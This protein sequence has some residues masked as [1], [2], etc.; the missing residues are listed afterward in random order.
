MFM[1][2]DDKTCNRTYGMITRSMVE[3]SK[4]TAI[5]V[6]NLGPELNFVA[7]STYSTI[8]PYLSEKSKE[9]PQ[10]DL[11]GAVWNYLDSFYSVL[12]GFS[13]LADSDNHRQIATKVKGLTNIANGIQLTTLTLLNYTS[14]AGF[15]FAAGAGLSFLHSLDDTIRCARRLLDYEYW[16]KDSEAEYQNL[17][18]QQTILKGEIAALEAREGIEDNPLSWLE[19]KTLGLKRERLGELAVNIEKL[20]ADIDAVKEVKRLT[21]E[22][23]RKARKQ[24]LDASLNSFAQG[25]SFIGMLIFCFPDVDVSAATFV[26]VAAGLYLFKHMGSQRFFGLI[27]DNKLPESEHEKDTDNLILESGDCPSTGIETGSDIEN[28]GVNVSHCEPDNED[29]DSDA[30]LSTEPLR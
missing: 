15:G 26:C 14:Y 3:A 19:E 11:V 13:Q 30:T 12:L 22:L 17:I 6:G 23:E 18:I 24:L 29:S 1:S 7:F 4:N 10:S 20:K 9:M 27:A 8:I 2:D 16:L 21:P 25:I 28:E 5:K